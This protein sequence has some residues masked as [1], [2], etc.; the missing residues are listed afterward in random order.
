MAEL[1]LSLQAPKVPAPTKGA[2]GGD[3]ETATMI[4]HSSWEPWV[5]QDRISKRCVFI[6]LFRNARLNWLLFKLM[7]MEAMRQSMVEENERQRRAQAQEHNNNAGSSEEPRSAQIPSFSR[8]SPESLLVDI[9]PGVSTSLPTSPSGPLAGPGTRSSAITRRPSHPT[10]SIPSALG[11]AVGVSPEG[12]SQSHAHI[13]V[14]QSDTPNSA[15]NP[16]AAD[17]TGTS[18]LPDETPP[19]QSWTGNEHDIEDEPSGISTP[20]L[21]NAQDEGLDSSVPSSSTTPVVMTFSF[22]HSFQTL[23]EGSHSQGL[24]FSPSD[25]R[26]SYSQA[27]ATPVSMASETAEEYD[28]LPSTPLSS[29]ASELSDRAPLIMQENEDDGSETGTLDDSESQFELPARAPIRA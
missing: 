7:I 29:R 13:R 1:W 20:R 14:V 10:F 27:M 25:D 15:L 11:S 26:P 9:S 19:T 8:H 2:T 3:D 18:T 5:W 16:V 4:C 6:Y 22:D 23:A 21:G 28:F 24:A 12:S 17:N